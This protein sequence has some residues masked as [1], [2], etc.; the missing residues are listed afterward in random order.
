MSLSP[1]QPEPEAPSVN[2]VRVVTDVVLTAC[3][4]YQVWKVIVPESVKIDI[5]AKWAQLSR[6]SPETS[7][8]HANAHLRFAL[9]QLEAADGETIGREAA[10]LA[11][12]S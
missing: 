12:A 8:R 1:E 6:P 9:A 5:K 10:R 4:V 7:R 3:V 2:W 11:R